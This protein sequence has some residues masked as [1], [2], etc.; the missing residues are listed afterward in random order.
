MGAGSSLEAAYHL[1]GPIHAGAWHLVGDGLILNA[2]D[3]R[4]DV[5]WRAA[6]GDQVVV[7][8]THHFAPPAAP[9]QFNAVAFDGDAT[10][11][12]VPASASDQLVLRMT[13][14]NGPTAPSYLPNG[15]G[16]NT[17]GRIP[18]LTLPR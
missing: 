1:Q 15:D 9:N 12:A 7:S 14:T 8:F 10:G 17:K 6:A 4:F 5:I 16:A 3:V 2:A 13:V 18:A 11:A